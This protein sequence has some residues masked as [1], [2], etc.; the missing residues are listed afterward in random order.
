M[1]KLKPHK[2]PSLP[3]LPGFCEHFRVRAQKI[4]KPFASGQHLQVWRGQSMEFRDFAPYTPGDDIRY[5]DWRASLRSGDDAKWFIRQFQAEES[6][7][8]VVSIDTR[9]SMYLPLKYPKIDYAAWGAEALARIGLRSDDKV[10]FHSLFGV[11]RGLTP[12]TRSGAARN[13]RPALSE[14]VRDAEVETPDIKINLEQ[15]QG[16]FFNNAVWVI[17]SDFYFLSNEDLRH[18]LAGFIRNAEKGW[19]WVILLN[20]DSWPCEAKGLSGGSSNAARRVAGPARDD[21][22]ELETNAETLA[23]VEKNIQAPQDEFLR[24]I[25]REG[26][27]QVWRWPETEITDPLAFFISCFANEPQGSNNRQNPFN[28]LFKRSR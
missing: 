28:R 1:K 18:Q 12:L 5:V 22:E 26:F 16:G 23:I 25:Q 19:R 7:H 2:L 15:L 14:M 17:F 11:N 3:K 20:L 27:D 4:Q 13:V 6:L 10:Y 24:S 8:L 21:F 9:E